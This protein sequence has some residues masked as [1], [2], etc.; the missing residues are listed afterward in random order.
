MPVKGAVY[1]IRTAE[2]SNCCPQHAGELYLRLE[3]IVIT[4]CPNTPY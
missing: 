1:T 3:E 2:R 4:V